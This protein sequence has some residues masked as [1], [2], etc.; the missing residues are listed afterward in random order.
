M[1]SVELTAAPTYMPLVS[2]S[3]GA[4][5]GATRVTT[6]ILNCGHIACPMLPEEREQS[7]AEWIGELAEDLEVVDG[8]L[9]GDGRDVMF[10]CHEPH[11]MASPT[12][13]QAI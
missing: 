12:F 5:P 3:A 6:R 13:V 9:L 1:T 7:K 4:D 8:Q 2:S 10:N 11:R